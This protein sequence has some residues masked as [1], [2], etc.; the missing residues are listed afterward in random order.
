MTG[1]DF[2]DQT[3]RLRQNRETMCWEITECS[4]AHPAAPAEP[5]LAA[6]AALVQEEGTW[7]GTAMELVEALQNREPE[8]K[9]WPN[10]LSRKLRTPQ[11][12]KDFGIR[13]TQ[14]RN[15]NG[16]YL[17]LSTMTDMSDG[18]G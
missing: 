15:Q 1:R 10:T 13:L 4:D 18:G 7:K 17:E 14:S 9:V 5:V 8:L 2:E 12:Q 16:K 3:F 11:L 6:V